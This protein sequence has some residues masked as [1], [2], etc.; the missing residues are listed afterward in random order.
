[1]DYATKIYLDNLIEAVEK[2]NS[3]DWWSIGI[4]V[5]NAAIMIWLGWNQYKLQKRQ[6][7]A[8]DYDTHKR[9]FV[10]L[11]NA[12]NE[13]DNFLC[14]LWRHLW[15]PSYTNNKDYLVNKHIYL[16][17]LKKDLADSYIDY[18]LKFPT[19]TFDKDGYYQIL[20][21]MASLTQQISSSIDEGIIELV[22]GVQKIYITDK[23]DE[24]YAEEISKLFKEHFDQC[25][26][27]HNLTGFIKQ[28][29]AVRCDNSLLEGI[30]AKCKID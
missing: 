26:C 7:E 14:D 21:L 22:Q 10:L 15:E 16:K 19:I 20:S 13:I 18:E 27:L 24:A 9:L 28:K 23:E 12:N 30:R 2:L 29:R 25:L 1:M 11:S 4:T 17:N 6:T 3:P 5:V 8:I